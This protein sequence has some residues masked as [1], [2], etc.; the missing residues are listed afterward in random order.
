MNESF[1]SNS[2]NETFLYNES[3]SD[4]KI[5]I[6]R[7]YKKS[8]TIKASPTSFTFGKIKSSASKEISNFGT[9]SKLNRNESSSEKFEMNNLNNDNI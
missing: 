3:F 7:N 8:K 6:N 2:L 5:R 1:V 9:S 4:N